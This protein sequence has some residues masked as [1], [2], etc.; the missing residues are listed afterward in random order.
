MKP[1][2]NFPAARWLF[3]TSLFLLVVVS[4]KKEAKDLV[5]KKNNAQAEST[6]NNNGRGH[7][8]QTKTFSSEV[9]V[10]WLNMQLDM[11]RVPLAAGTGSQSA[12]RAHAYAGL[13]LYE[14]VVPGMPAYQSLSGQLTAFPAMPETEPGE[15]YH[16]AA[17]A[18]ATL[19]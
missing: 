14:A 5:G 17:V 6:Q 1:L 4:C 3:L 19:A 15:A 18:N 10:K 2:I 13:A 7:L 8:Q 16:W 12:D 9:V 11:L